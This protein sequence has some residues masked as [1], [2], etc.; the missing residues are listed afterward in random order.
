MVVHLP[1]TTPLDGCV[2]SIWNELQ[3]LGASPSKA[4]VLG[5]AYEAILEDEEAV[6]GTTLRKPGGVFYTPP[7]VVDYIVR[8]TVPPDLTDS[9]PIAILDPAC[10]AGAFLEAAARCILESRRD[11]PRSMHERVVGRSVFGVDVDPRAA[12]LA[13]TSMALQARERASA[14]SLR[15]LVGALNKHIVGGSSLVEPGPDGPILS[16]IETAFGDVL[17]R[18]GFDL[19]LGNPPYVKNKDL[20]AGRKQLWS[21][22]YRCARGQFDLM[23]LFLEKGL[24]VLRP[25]GRLGFLVSNKFMA[26]DYGKEIRRR[27]LDTCQIEEITDLS[28]AQIF[29]EAA[30][31]PT[32][33]IL[34]KHARRRSAGGKVLLRHGVK[35]LS[36]PGGVSIPQSYF[37]RRSDRI[38]TTA[39][40]HSSLRLLR[41][42]E[43]GARP[44]G[45]LMSVGCG[46]ADPGMA[47]LFCDGIDAPRRPSGT[48]V[49]PFIR[50]E[51]IRPYEICWTDR[52]V[53]LDPDRY[54]PDRVAAFGGKK[55]VIP[56]VRP[57]LQAA[58]DARGYALGRVYYIPASGNDHRLLL[59]LLNSSVLDW[60][61]RTVFEAVRM[62]GGFLRFNGPYLKA[63]PIPVCG[64]D[65]PRI[66][67]IRSKVSR[68]LRRA[69]RDAD[70]PTPSLASSLEREIDHSVADLYELSAAERQRIGLAAH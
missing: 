32:I 50:V 54:S 38:L 19:V 65:D 56:G 22:T 4:G 66:A 13:R 34:R 26:S 16:T 62:A 37:E 47:R 8:K 60:Y 42:I 25:G 58:Y 36:A 39:V 31:Y 49:F 18:G 1:S 2:G 27:I 44:L 51:N 61:Y 23:V 63:L 33:L 40:T 45:E 41:R 10:G 48:S 30:V 59:A 24:E 9:G 29:R 3:T 15:S 69:K 68:R 14:A 57:T 17:G 28:S 21:R 70:D 20:D 6:S 12:R 55:I 46:L 5:V 43:N 53:C 7:E 52:W 64:D 11:A 35:D 67:A